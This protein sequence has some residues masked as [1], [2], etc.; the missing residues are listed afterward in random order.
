MLIFSSPSSEV[1]DTIVSSRPHTH[2]HI[3]RFCSISYT[4]CYLASAA[5]LSLERVGNVP[6]SHYY[7]SFRVMKWVAQVHARSGPGVSIQILTFPSSLAFLPH[8]IIT[9]HYLPGISNAEESPRT[10]FP[11]QRSHTMWSLQMLQMF[12]CVCLTLNFVS[13]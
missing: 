9:T 7:Y 2:A 12:R 10:P 11:T 6:P 8:R 1:H 4:E 13:F 3:I 5:S